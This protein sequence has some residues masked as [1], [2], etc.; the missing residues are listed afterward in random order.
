MSVCT[1]IASDHPLPEIAPSQDYPLEINIDTGTIYDG[2]ADDNFFLHIFNDVQSYTD[3]KYGVWLEWYYTD[4]RADNII[5]YIKDNLKHT[6]TIEFWH[7]WLADYYEYEE[8]P[9]IHSR[10]ISAEELTVKDIRDTD[11]AQIWN[12][13]DKTYPDRPSF[14]RLIITP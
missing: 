9:V 1:F 8:S 14:Y 3:K 7:V 10:I 13:P 2:G 6:N 11:S 4:G 12:T 5:K